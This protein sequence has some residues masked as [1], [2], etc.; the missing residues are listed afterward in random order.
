MDNLRRLDHAVL[1]VETLTVARARLEALGFR[2]ANDARHPFGTE[3]ACVYFADQ[4]YLEPLAVADDMAMQHSVTEGNNF[5]RLFGQYRHSTETEGFAA[6]ALKSSD[7][8]GDHGYFQETGISAGGMLAFSRPLKRPDGTETVASFKLAF[9]AKP[10]EERFYVFTCQRIN[11]SALADEALLAHENGVVG[12]KGIILLSKEASDR[13][14]LG[15]IFGAAVEDE[16]G[17]AFVMNGSKLHVMEEEG[18]RDYVG[19]ACATKA[20]GLTGIAVVFGVRDVRKTAELFEARGI[21]YEKRA[22]RL[23]VAAEAGQGAIFVFEEEAA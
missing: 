11:V 5:T 3:N 15:A 9:S 7:A 16:Y 4:T 12:T 8:D 20:E 1:S 10:A 6:I 14:Y 19:A 18:L 21:A 17:L 23:V 13:N 2:V 22:D